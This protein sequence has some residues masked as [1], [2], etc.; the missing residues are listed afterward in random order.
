M[1]I[2]GLLDLPT[3]QDIFEVEFTPIAPQENLVFARH[4]EARRGDFKV[5]GI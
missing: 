1:G 3:G 4:P 5:I 2:S